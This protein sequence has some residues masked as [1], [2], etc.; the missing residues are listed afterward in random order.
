VVG[1]GRGECA[2]AAA[3]ADAS[4]FFE[5]S[6]DLRVMSPTKIGD[7]RAID[8][9]STTP[10]RMVV[11]AGTLADA[12][13]AIALC[14]KDERLFCTVGCHPTRGTEA[15]EYPGGLSAYMAELEMVAREGGD[16]VVA[17][18]ECGLD[19]ARLQFCPAETQLEVFE[20]HFGL[21]ERLGK[22]LFLHLRDAADAFVPLVR[23]HKAAVAAGGGGVVH[24]FDGTA[25]TLDDLLELG[26]HIGLNGCSL[27][28][29]ENLA[30]AARVPAGRLLIETDSPWCD[31]RPTHASARLAGD[32]PRG[33]DKKKKGTQGVGMV[34]G[35]NEPAN[36]CTVFR[37]VA[38]LLASE[39]GGEDGLANEIRAA[40]WQL[41]WPHEALPE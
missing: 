3:G 11:T 36:V 18:G 10:Q 27:R 20:A 17:V 34:K 38:G 32:L 39:R 26:L 33:I 25:A 21:A 35:R 16:R 40:S 28:T 29:E 7:Q 23:R 31:V 1:G 41:F 9:P 5:P 13:E 12:K 24:S 6:D 30:V 37:V 2:D 15:V 8:Q 4:V 19:Y 14:S 22:P